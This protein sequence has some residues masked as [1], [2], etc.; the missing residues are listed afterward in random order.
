VLSPMIKDVDA[1][2]RLWNG[3]WIS[4]IVKCFV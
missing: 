2:N 3:I 1:T 4:G